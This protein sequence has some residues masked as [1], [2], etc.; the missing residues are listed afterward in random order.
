M[1]SMALRAAATDAGGPPDDL[2]VGERQVEGGD[3]AGDQPRE[4]L[5]RRTDAVLAHPAPVGNQVDER[6]DG[7][8]ELQRQDHLRQ[9]EQLPGGLFAGEQDRRHRRHQGQAARDQPSYQGPQA[10]VKEAL[11]DDLTGESAGDGGRLAGGD[12]GDGKGDRSE[13]HAEDGLE[14][15]VRL[16]DLGDPGVAGLKEGGGRHDQ[17]R[18]VDQE[19]A[20]EGDHRVDD[21]EAHA[22]SDAGRGVHDAP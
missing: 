19:G 21:V 2:I 5:H 14:Q 17:E 6:Y 20:V 11:H 10:Q 12:E 1:I 22:A 3:G 15:A 13:V 9:D 4:P 16:L 18:R 8:G 7:E